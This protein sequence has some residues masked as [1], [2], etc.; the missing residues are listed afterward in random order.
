MDGSARNERRFARA[1]FNCLAV[2]SHSQGA[3]INGWELG[4]NSPRN[5]INGGPI[6]RLGMDLDC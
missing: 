5:N 6:S 4:L 2:E 1:H 3:R